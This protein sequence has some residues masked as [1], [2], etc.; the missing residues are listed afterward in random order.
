MPMQERL[1]ASVPVLAR[2]PKNNAERQQEFSIAINIIFWVILIAVLLKKIHSIG[3][4]QEEEKKA[5]ELEREQSFIEAGEELNEIA[6]AVA[7]QRQYVLSLVKD[8]DVI[9][10]DTQINEDKLEEEIDDFFFPM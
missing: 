1:I 3:L 5:E 8:G 7:F 10:K 2:T 4:E 9:S 6:L